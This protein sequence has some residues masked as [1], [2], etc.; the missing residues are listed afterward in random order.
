MKMRLL[1]L[2]LGSVLTLAGVIVPA[3]SASADSSTCYTGCTTPG[4][5]TTP[6]GPAPTTKVD[7]VSTGALAF[8]G[9]DIGEMT[10]IGAGSLVL[11][12]VLVRRGRRRSRTA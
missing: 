6:D 11:G 7:T 5:P 8:T 4:V 9:A 1:G 3:V 2:G 10:A 12:G